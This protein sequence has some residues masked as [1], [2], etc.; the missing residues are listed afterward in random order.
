M[1]WNKFLTD[2]LDSN[3]TLSKPNFEGEEE[4]GFTVGVMQAPNNSTRLWR[5]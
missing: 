5:Q 4:D 1:G 2:L 3:F